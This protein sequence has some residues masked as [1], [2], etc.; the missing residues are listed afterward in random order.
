MNWLDVV[1]V[2]WMLWSVRSGMRRGLVCE[3]C[4][5]GT[6]L[7]ALLTAYRYA[8]V[9][10]EPLVVRYGIPQ[11][12]AAGFIGTV[13]VVGSAMIGYALEPIIAASVRSNRQG[14][15]VDRWGGACAG[16]VKGALLTVLV[17]VGVYQLPWQFGH[18]SI[19]RSY[20]A[21]QVMRLAR[22]FYGQLN[23]VLAE[24]DG[25]SVTRIVP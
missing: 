13:V 21:V 23:Q 20:L 8:A 22:S 24:G 5:V 11:A 6:V 25:G 14:L 12:V 19:D 3:V 9:W 7:A 10:A 18:R 17:I 15:A 2:A 1:I 4:R 16:I